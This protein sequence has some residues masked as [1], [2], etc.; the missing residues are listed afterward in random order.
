[1]DADELVGPI[2]TANPFLNN[3]LQQTR[4]ARGRVFWLCMTGRYP[5]KTVKLK[6]H[7]GD[8]SGE[9]RSNGSQSIIHGIHPNGNEYQV[10]NMAKPLKVSFTDIVWPPEII[11]PQKLGCIEEDRRDSS[12][13]SS[14]GSSVPSVSSIQQNG[15]K[16]LNLE[17][18]LRRCVPEGV[19]QNNRKLFNLARGVKTLERLEGVIFLEVRLRGAFEQWHARSLKY[20]R[21]EL[22]AELGAAFL[23]GHAG[24]VERT[25]EN[26]AAY[27][28]AWLERL[29]EDRRLIVRAAAAA[30][31]AADF[32]LG[33]QFPQLETEG[34]E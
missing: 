16:I 18:I 29:K 23:S 34:N 12:H 2:L 33:T 26:S 20:A 28:Q 14:S 25:L 15:L 22:V 31:K 17:D 6:T 27:L 21:E 32:I 4:G 19:H 5:G 30:Q 24:I 9:F 8:D 13:S 3:T 7:S 1:V 10:L 11:N